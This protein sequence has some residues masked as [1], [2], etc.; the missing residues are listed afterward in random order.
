MKA[1]FLVLAIALVVL[2]NVDAGCEQQTPPCTC[3][4]GEG[5]WKSG[6]SGCKYICKE[7]VVEL[8]CAQAEETFKREQKEG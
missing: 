8:T 2:H 6:A 3:K 7:G 1:V 4:V 5:A